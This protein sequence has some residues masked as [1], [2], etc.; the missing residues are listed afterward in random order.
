M[1][2]LLHRLFLG[3]AALL[4][5][6]SPGFAPIGA[7]TVDS[8]LDARPA[9]WVVRDRDT[10]IYLF[11]SIHV[12]KPGVR[13]FKGPVRTAF[14]RSDELVLE[15]LT[16]DRQEVATKTARLAVDPDGPPLTEKLPAP[17]RARYLALL[18]KLGVPADRLEPFQPWFAAITLS[19]LPLEKIGY[20]ADSGAEDVLKKAAAAKA[21]KMDAL[22]TIDQQL[23]YFAALPEAV[24][25]AFLSATIDDA[26]KAETEIGAMVAN[27][28][29]GK[30]EALAARM[31][32]TLKEMPEVAQALL[33]DR[34][35]RWAGWVAERMKRPGTV[36]LAVGAGHL[37]GKGSLLDD[38]AAQGMQVRR[39]E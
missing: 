35:R 19:I 14:D 7:R 4:L 13:W 24:Q 39:V 3:L 22:E 36:F 38:L 15:V 25:I 33:Y 27:W 31:N 32:D 10:T 11:G 29:A 20:S 18:A 23:G 6:T 9:L 12:L 1:F 34:N 2:S 5:L 8:G 37:A 28:G 17:V 30:P 26:D 21:K 16:P